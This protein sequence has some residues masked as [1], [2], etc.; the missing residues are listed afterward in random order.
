[1]SL[2]T[3]KKIETNVYELEISIDA[4]T[5]EQAVQKAYN[6]LKN[7]ISV[8]GFRKGKA[9]RAMIEKMYGVELLYED[10]IEIVYPEA[11]ESAIKEADLKIVD[12]PYDVEV[13]EIGK[14]GALIRL[15]VTVSPEV[16]L[17]D[18]K[19]LE[20]T[21]IPVIVE[22]FEIDEQINQMLER[23]A[24]YISIEDRDIIDGDMV[25]INFEGFVDGVA[26]EGGK[27]ENYDL[28]IG[29]GAFIPGFE[30]QLIGHKSGEEFDI[31]IKFPAEYAENLAGKDAVF[32][33]KINEIKQKELPELDDDFAKDVS[34]FDTIDELKSDLHKQ[35]EERKINE[36]EASVEEQ[37][38]E[39]LAGLVKAEIP[40]VMIEKTMDDSVNEFAYRMQSQGMDLDTYLQFTGMTKEDFR[41]SLREKSETQVKIDLALEKIIELEKIEVTPEALEGE[42][43]KFAQMYGVEIDVVKN[44]IPEEEASSGLRTTQ[45]LD[46]LKENAKIIEKKPEKADDKKEEKAEKKPAAKK[47]TTKKA[48]D[49]KAEKKPAA[50]KTTTKKADDE[51]AEKKPATKKATT[52]KADDEKAEK[53][54]AAKKPA[55]KKTTAKKTEAEEK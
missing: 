47:A 24:R 53:K 23:N 46:L 42:Y 51:K 22:D 12:M 13:P 10:A 21:K 48:D 35:L 7:K 37:L 44:A 14:D 19:S 36:I 29:S 3:S 16:E 31:D 11:V 25:S 8:P 40:Q 17:G 20:A 15:K 52:K 41:E 50:K 38:L 28:T 30:D 1:M 45:V 39:Q 26:F 27:A 6:K 5:F 34:E 32:K 18:Y 33:I 54:P 49:E 43:Q 2:K 4:V 9:P 55:A